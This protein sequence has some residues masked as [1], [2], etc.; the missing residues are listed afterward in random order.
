MANEQRT[1]VAGE[2]SLIASIQS[3]MAGLRE[4]LLEFDK[5]YEQRFALQKEI[6]SNALFNAEKAVTVAEIN[7]EKWRAN[8]NEWRSAMDDRETRFVL[9]DQ[10]NPTIQGIQKEVDQLRTQ[11]NLDTG[12]SMGYA[13]IWTYIVAAAGSGGVLAWIAAHFSK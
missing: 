5:R 2:A 13:Q 12:K 7:S 3:E 8:A 11:S 10:L 6:F 9:K 1:T 4:L